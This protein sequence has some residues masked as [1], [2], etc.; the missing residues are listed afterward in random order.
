MI[1]GVEIGDPW[2]AIVDLAMGI[3]GRPVMLE[4]A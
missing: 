1:K 2:D 4:K 3:S